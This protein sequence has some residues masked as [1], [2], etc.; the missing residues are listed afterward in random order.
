M[1]AD[2][3]S[4]RGQTIQAEWSLLPD[5]I[6]LIC[7]R[8]HQPQVDLFATRFNNKLPQHVSP[9]SDPWLV[10][11]MHFACPERIWPLCLPTFSHREQTDEV[12]GIPMQENHSDCSRVAKHALV[13]GPSDHVRSHYTC[14]TC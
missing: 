11:W 7:T 9:V 2:K 1:I 14:P 8:W 5:V 13:L 12:A 6:Q 4:R 3:L 10:Q